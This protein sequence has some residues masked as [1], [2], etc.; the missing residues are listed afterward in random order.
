M[1]AIW[2]GFTSSPRH[3][4]EC[5]PQLDAPPVNIDN[6]S[7]PPQA[8]PAT[9]G[10]I[11]ERAETMRD[12]LSPSRTVWG[13]LCL[14]LLQLTV[15]RGALAQ[16]QTAS[17]IATCGVLVAI[18]SDVGLQTDDGSIFVISNPGGFATGERVFV[19]GALVN[20]GASL[21]GCV[22]PTN[23]SLC[24]PE[25]FRRGDCNRDGGRNVGDAITILSALF[26]AFGVV[27]DVG[28]LDACDGNDDG[29][30]D[31]A[32]A[33]TLLHTLFLGAPLP[34]PF[35]ACGIDPTD[36]DSLSCNEPSPCP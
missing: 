22:T 3:P 18:G 1:L 29:S 33:V 23:I 30:V 25:A 15:P 19:E 31:V 7:V 5:D 28:C 36:Q 2:R 12:R 26:V 6:L 9:R 14:A 11:D 32:D 34:A 13:L 17:P 35:P 27:I 20:C 4:E 10:R 24:N 8:A 21:S 16:T